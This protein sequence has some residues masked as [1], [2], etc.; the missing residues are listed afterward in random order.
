MYLFTPP[1]GCPNWR[2]KYRIEGKEKTYSISPY[3]LV[4]LAAARITLG[5][6]KALLLENKDP[7]TERRLNRA[8]TAAGSDN[9]FGAVAHEWLAMKR[10]EWSA[11]HHA[12]SSHA[13]ERDIYP[14]LGKLPIARISPAI[15]AKA[16][17]D[18]HKRD[19]LETA[20]R[21]LQQLNGVF[22]YASPRDCAGTTR[23]RLRG[24][25]CRARRTVGACRR[26]PTSLL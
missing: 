8:A 17:E 20:S 23:R 21:I 6:V 1:A 11:G 3:P 18:I 13:F 9:T 2:I 16:I 12:K 15:V 19:V 14:I 24:K 5:E 22:R 25:F 7:V 26:S 10:K 4:S